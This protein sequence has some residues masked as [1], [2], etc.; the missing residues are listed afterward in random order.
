[1]NRDDVIDVLTLIA[2]VD[3]RTVGEA[4]VTAWGVIIGE[5]PREFA[6]KAVT[7]HRREEPGTWLEPGHVYQRARAMVRDKLEHEPDAFREAR[8]AILDAKNAPTED[9]P[10]PAFSGPVKHHRPYPNPLK[11]W[12]PHCGAGP[13]KHCSVPG[14]SRR[15][16][17]G[18]HP[19]RIEAAQALVNS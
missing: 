11:V 17:G 14:T 12:C 7:D 4:D 16:H 8:Q 3:H 1:M 6:I 19:A 13:F 9:D 15:P 10:Q 2:A 18:M 5:L